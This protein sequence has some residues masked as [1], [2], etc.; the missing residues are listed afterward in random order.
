M[1]A[2]RKGSST[3]E[4]RLIRSLEACTNPLRQSSVERP[5]RLEGFGPVVSKWMTAFRRRRTQVCHSRWKRPLGRLVK[6]IRK[7]D[8]P[9]RP[10]VD[11]EHGLCAWMCMQ[12]RQLRGRSG[13]THQPL[14]TSATASSRKSIRLM[15]E[16][17][18]QHIGYNCQHEFQSRAALLMLGKE[19]GKKKHIGF[20][21]GGPL[22]G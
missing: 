9:P 10:R 11:G 22:H 16:L 5:L 14:H 13:S 15:L 18:L 2:R 8:R 12:R 21:K 1:P 4:C 3:L 7:H 6:F 19:G 17:E 20:W